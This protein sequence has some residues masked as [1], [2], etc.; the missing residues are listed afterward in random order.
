MEDSNNSIDFFDP[1]SADFSKPDSLTYDRIILEQIR[2]C[3]VE[4]SKEMKEGYVS[5]IKNNEGGFIPIVFPDQRKVYISSVQALYDLILPKIDKKGD[6]KRLA[7][8]LAERNSA[9]D[10]WY[11]VYIN[12]L[13]PEDKRKANSILGKKKN[14]AVN[15]GMGSVCLSNYY[16]DLVD[17]YREIFQILVSIYNDVFAERGVER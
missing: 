11:E 8:K 3:S 4:G 13:S 14:I 15:I 12:N 9:Y 16:S 10:N 1:E 7:D 6:E 17:I 2:R 5:Y